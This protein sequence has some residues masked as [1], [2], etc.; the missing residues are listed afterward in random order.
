MS[1]FCVALYTQHAFNNMK[2]GDANT[3]AVAKNISIDKLEERG[4]LYAQKGVVRLLDRSEISD[5]GSGERILWL[6]TQQL[7]KAMEEGGIKACAEIVNRLF[8]S[9]G[10]Q[11]KTLA[12]RLYTIAEKK[13]WATEAYAYNSLVVSWPD[14]QSAAAELASVNPEQVVLF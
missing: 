3:L 5:G 12:Y 10:E 4:V 11:A 6:L 8:G 14:I 1:Q 9:L 2:F 13:G 7:T